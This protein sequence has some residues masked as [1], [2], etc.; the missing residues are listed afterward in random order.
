MKFYD[1]LAKKTNGD[2]VSM[3]T[4][5]GKVTLIV[6]TANHCQFTYQ[7]DDLQ[8]LYEKY[9]SQGFTV[10]GFP[11]NQFANQNPE[12]GLE[13]ERTCQLN[14]G[15]KFPIYDVVDVNGDHTHP[16]FNYLKHA[17]D[18]RPIDKSNM[19]EAIL[20]DMIS[21]QYPTYLLDNNIR[22]NFTKFLIDAQG[23]VIQRFEPDDSI[24]DIERKIEQ[25]L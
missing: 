16:L 15:V 8:K 3:Q 11:S 14:Y 2:I 19:Q 18:A 21:Q 13:T 9:Q 7:F 12:T 4:Y 25:L 10:L 17:V 6:N 23:N 1:Y 22:W 24:I 5:K 20:M